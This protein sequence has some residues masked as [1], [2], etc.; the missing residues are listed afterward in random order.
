LNVIISGTVVLPQFAATLGGSDNEIERWTLDARDDLAELQLHLE[1][2]DIRGV[3]FVSET[4]TAD[5]SC[6]P[7]HDGRWHIADREW[8][9]A[10]GLDPRH[11]Q[12]RAC[13]RSSGTGRRWS[14]IPPRHGEVPM[15]QPKVVRENLVLYSTSMFA[16]A[17]AVLEQLTAEAPHRT[18]D[19]R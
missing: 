4:S 17:L 16:T 5:T 1:D 9:A 12:H 6:I 15:R 7:G 11:A 19:R 18:T 14:P 13:R 2:H 10:C 3:L 8:E